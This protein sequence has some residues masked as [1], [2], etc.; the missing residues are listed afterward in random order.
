[1]WL[2]TQVASAREAGRELS[3]ETQIVTLS[4]LNQSG[5]ASRVS[6]YNL[7]MNTSQIGFLDLRLGISSCQVSS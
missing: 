7:I 5:L 3:N 4:H 6:R 2:K 1:M